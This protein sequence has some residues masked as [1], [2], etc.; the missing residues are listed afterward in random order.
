MWGEG[1]GHSDGHKAPPV[2]SSRCWRAKSP[3]SRR[4]SPQ[5]AAEPALGAFGPL[6]VRAEGGLYGGAWSRQRVS[7]PALREPASVADG[8][9]QPG[10]TRCLLSLIAASRRA[11]LS[12]SGSWLLPRRRIVSSHRPAPAGLTAFPLRLPAQLCLARSVLPLASQCHLLSFS[13]PL[14]LDFP[15]FSPHS[16]VLPY[17]IFC[18]KVQKAVGL[19][20]GDAKLGCPLRRLASI[21]FTSSSALPGH[22][23]PNRA[24]LVGMRGALCGPGRTI[25]ALCRRKRLCPAAT[26]PRVRRACGRARVSLRSPARGAKARGRWGG[27]S[28]RPASPRSA[29]R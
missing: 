7:A 14:R 23:G 24:C 27:Q 18:T 12:Q 11:R 21:P 13:P 28:P 4:K 16:S 9:F 5:V 8:G 17:T 26:A 6:G 22:G 2:T 29:V 20:R 1:S 3:A 25:A 19:H 15:F 10:Q